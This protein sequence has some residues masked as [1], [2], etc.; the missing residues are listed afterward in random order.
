MGCST[1]S[2]SCPHIVENRADFHDK[3]AI[4]TLLGEGSFGRVFVVERRGRAID[5]PHP[6]ASMSRRAARSCDQDGALAT[7]HCVKV[8]YRGTRRVSSGTR[9][10]C[11]ARVTDA[12]T[13]EVNAWRCIG[14]HKH[15]VT[16]IEAFEQFDAWYMVM[17]RCDGSFLEK[18]TQVQKLLECDFTGVFREMS[19]GVAHL[20]QVGIV[21]RDI[22]VDN[23]LLGGPRG[24]TVKLGDFGFATPIPSD[25]LLT[26]VCGTPPYMSPEMLGGVGYDE[27]TDVW[28]LG[29]AIHYLLFQDYL[30]TP[31]RADGILMKRAI[32]ANSPRLD[33][34]WADAFDRSF[35]F[36]KSMLQRAPARRCSVQ[37][38]LDS[39]LNVSCNTSQVS[40]CEVR[41]IRQCLAMDIRM[42]RIGT[43]ARSEVSKEAHEEN[44][45]AV[46]KACTMSTNSSCG[47][48]EFQHTDTDYTISDS[49]GDE[50]SIQVPWATRLKQGC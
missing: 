48:G 31:A 28:S 42:V 19:L 5:E 25:E 43:R 18:W 4:G 9:A 50:A 7:E 45:E 13:A 47:G 40:L 12:S 1:S 17:E 32:L 24:L 14:E 23:F 35:S 20:H 29:G 41:K 39:S 46:S 26:E 3:Y 33:L 10:K 44:M 6:L 15:C 36:I 37:Q 27:K 49:L 21:H 34:H 16:L 30:Y 22:K 2:T 8:V 11:T 38:L